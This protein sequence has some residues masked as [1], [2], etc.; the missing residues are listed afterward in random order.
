[1]C[2]HDDPMFFGCR[3]ARDGA[4]EA[5]GKSKLAADGCAGPDPGS[6]LNCANSAVK[7]PN[8][9]VSSSIRMFFRSFF[10]IFL[11]C[12][13]QRCWVKAGGPDQL[14]V[15]IHGLVR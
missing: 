12:T 4:S 8:G 3:I 14:A 5:G 9:K 10:G 6:T 13:A 15:S 7:T 2:G 1:M 11:Y